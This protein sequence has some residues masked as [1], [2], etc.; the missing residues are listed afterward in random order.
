M[1]PR[2]RQQPHGCRF[3]GTLAALQEHRG[4]CNATWDELSHLRAQSDATQQAEHDPPVNS[5]TLTAHAP[6][7]PPS[8]RAN[9]PPT[10]TSSLAE[11]RKEDDP[12][13]PSVTP[14][15]EVSPGVTISKPAPKYK[16]RDEA[17]ISSSS[18]GE[19]LAIHS[20]AVKSSAAAPSRSSSASLESLL[21]EHETE[22]QGDP[23]GHHPQENGAVVDD[24]QLCVSPWIGSPSLVPQCP[25]EKR[26]SPPPPPPLKESFHEKRAA[27]G[28]NGP[29]KKRQRVE[30]EQVRN[31]GRAEHRSKGAAGST[32]A[33][34]EQTPSSHPPSQSNT[35]KPFSG[36]WLQPFAVIEADRVVC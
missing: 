10:P 18:A 9:L 31:N 34:T 33:G 22:H 7:L 2:C 3:I 4:F 11:H 25:A 32:L 23:E 15:S 20:R 24:L 17:S 13:D 36:S 21:I 14:G 26:K 16:P 19:E 6:G 35:K 8:R 27:T 12:S 5:T 30:V 28:S 1:T 29:P